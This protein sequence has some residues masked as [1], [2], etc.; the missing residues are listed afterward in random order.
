MIIIKKYSTNMFDEVKLLIKSTSNKAN[1]AL[2]KSSKFNDE[3]QIFWCLFNDIELIGT[4][5]LFKNLT[6]VGSVELFHISQK[7][8]NLQMEQKLLFHLI[9]ESI[10]KGYS[11]IYLQNVQSTILDELFTANELDKND[12]SS[13]NLLNHGITYSINHLFNLAKKTLILNPTENIP[14]QKSVSAN[15]T[16]GYYV[17]YQKR[18]QNN[19]LIFAGRDSYRRLLENIKHR[20]KQQLRSDDISFQALS[21]IHA[22]TLLFMSIGSF[23]DRILILPYKAGGH[24]TTHTILNRL[25]FNVKEMIVDN[26]N[27]CIDINKTK[28]LINNFNPKY[29]FVGRSDGLYFEDF[30]WLKDP[31]YCHIHKIF[32]A[33]QYLTQI[34]Y[35]TSYKHPY[36]MGF[37]IIITTIHK[38]FPGPQ[39]ALIATNCIDHIWSKFVS[40]SQLYVSNL[41]PLDII[42]SHFDLGEHSYLHTYSKKMIEFKTEFTNQLHEYGFTVIHNMKNNIPTHHVWIL[43]KTKIE[44]YTLFKNLES[45]DILVN[46]INLP[47]NLGYGLRIGF[48]AAIRQGILLDNLSVLAKLIYDIQKGGTSIDNIK[49][50]RNFLNFLSLK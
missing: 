29:I 32:D 5:A 39:K 15:F 34:M 35:D 22:H 3:S 4:I 19:T 10:S 13:L 49:K 36:D 41:H 12:H 17:N 7:Y 18:D 9:T 20:W 21:G 23:N 14:L 31:S 37:N 30:S 47:Y 50:T 8:I 25:G 1:L 27:H 42:N 44:A 45:L 48:G 16:E 6:T 33:S 11:K 43:F 26:R 2:F 24:I 28:N 38:N 40:N 46:Y